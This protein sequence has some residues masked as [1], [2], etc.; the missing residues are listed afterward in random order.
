MESHKLQ[1]FDN[2]LAYTH[3]KK[4]KGRKSHRQTMLV[5]FFFM[6]FWAL[7]SLAQQ[8]KTSRR[9]PNASVGRFELQFFYKSI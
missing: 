7:K 3:T 6:E 9:K 1:K 8:F 4:V 2:N 5:V